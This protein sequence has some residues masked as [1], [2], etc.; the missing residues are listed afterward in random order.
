MLYTPSWEIMHCARCEMPIPI[1]T[2]GINDDTCPCSDLPSWPNLDLPHPHVPGD[3]EDKL[4]EI[5]LKLK[6]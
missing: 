2:A 5:H 1:P 4:H 3:V 6:K